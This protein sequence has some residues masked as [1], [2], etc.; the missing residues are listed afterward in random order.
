MIKDRDALALGQLGRQNTGHFMVKFCHDVRT[1]HRKAVAIALNIGIGEGV[2]RVLDIGCG[3]GYFLKVCQEFSCEAVGLDVPDTLIEE[4]AKI[5]GVVYRPFTVTNFVPLPSEYQELDLVTTFGVNFR[6]SAEQNAGDDY[7]G[8]DEYAFLARDIMPRLTQHGRWVLRPNR[9]SE[10]ANEW[11]DLA[12]RCK[13][14]QRIGDIAN[15]VVS[16]EQVT[17]MSKA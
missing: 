17:I 13:W 6:R 5:I 8:W 15:V 1:W 9:R 2:D 3:F 12:D 10:S 16:G 14:N 11:S 4:A 7:W